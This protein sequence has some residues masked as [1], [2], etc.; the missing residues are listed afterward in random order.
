MGA[1]SLNGPSSFKRRIKCPASARMEKDIPSTSSIYAAEGTA[2]HD[3]G[4]KCL[5]TGLNAV[6]YLGT[7]ISVNKDG[8]SNEFEVTREMVDAVQ[9]Y[10]DYCRQYMGEHMIE[11]KLQLPFLGEGTK[12]TA[13]FIAL[14]GGVLH[15]VDYKHGKGVAVDVI[16]NVQGLCYAMGAAE[17]YKDKTWDGV[18]ITIVQP[19]AYHDDGPI[20]SWAVDRN[21]IFD[22][23]FAYATYAARTLDP[24]ASFEVGDHCRF[25]KAKPTCPAQKTFAE[26]NMD[27]DF[28]DP[29]SK[30]IPV[31]MIDDETLS[32]LILNRIKLIE[33]WCQSVKDHGQQRAEQNKPLPGTKLVHTRN[34]R[35]WK[36]KGEAERV[37]RGVLGDDA[38]KKSFK[39]APQI[40]KVVGK[41]EFEKYDHMVDEVATGVTLVHDS[42]PRPDVRP[43]AELEFSS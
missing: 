30:P 32:D 41:K 40:E 31:N 16:E 6:D 17:V 39:S 2:A 9:V 34:S 24:D 21:Y 29:T 19:R 35:I 14:H 28:S 8:A 4:E 42:D 38:Y 36:D 22:E 5:K 15:V 12:G 10:V 26:K 18:E 25:C 37:F 43:S 13:D 3:L 1:H 7:F 23:M 20:R 27:M 11:E 33:Q